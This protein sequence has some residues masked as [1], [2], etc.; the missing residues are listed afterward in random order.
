MRIAI[1]RSRCLLLAACCVAAEHPHKATAA[2]ERFRLDNG[3]QVI[4]RPI[5]GAGDVACIVLYDVG[6]DHDPKGRSGLAH[7]VEH[8][9]V[10]AAAGPEAPRTAD[11][12]FRRYPAGANA[13]T[14]DRYTVVAT[15]FPK[16]SLD[17]ELRDASAR[18]GDLKITPA[19]LDRERARLLDEVANMFGRIPALGALNN[20]RELVRPTPQGGRKGGQPDQVKAIT[21][22]ELGAHWRRY[23]KPR[24]AILVLAGGVE[25]AEAKK[26]VTTHFGGLPAGDELPKPHELGKPRFGETVSL[27]V[28]SA[29][30]GS[31][32]EGCLMYA[33]PE[34]G[35]TLYA[36]F[37]VIAARLYASAAKSRTAPGRFPIYYPLLD[38]PA[39]IGVNAAAGPNESDKELYTRLEV[40]ISS[41]V[42][43]ELREVDRARTEQTFGLFLGLMDVPDAAL[44]RNPYSVAFAVGR[45]EQLGLDPAK[46]KQSL[47][48]VTEQDLRRAAVEVFAPTRHT[49]AIVSVRR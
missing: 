46:L 45:R 6:G 37:L 1:L 5:R 39:V 22:D 38:D 15:V 35:S 43:P 27:A 33:A 9:Y 44:A 34:P 10:T 30:P 7:L 4:I 49:G 41:A 36:P 21:L 16:A 18:M 24:N 23:Y 13:Q 17:K 29:V 40:M 31:E 19:D 48:A 20:A 8:L 47:R 32:R 11:A 25:P 12:L 14:G 26:A 42:E 3:L 28:E 2:E